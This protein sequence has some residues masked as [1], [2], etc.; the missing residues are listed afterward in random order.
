M[1]YPF[2]HPVRTKLRVCKDTPPDSSSA[3]LE[4]AT[5]NFTPDNGKSRKA[6]KRCEF[7][8]LLKERF[9]NV[10]HKYMVLKV[11][12][13]KYIA[14]TKKPPYKATMLAAKVVATTLKCYVL[15]VALASIELV[16]FLVEVVP[17][18]KSKN[19]EGADEDEKA[20]VYAHLMVGNQHPELLALA[21]SCC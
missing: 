1:K 17:A 20:D 4:Q 21:P 9:Y 2:T 10:S 16:N 18:K 14:A 3:T 8:E 19:R 5:G 12:R 13:G 15:S 11:L 7:A 6:S